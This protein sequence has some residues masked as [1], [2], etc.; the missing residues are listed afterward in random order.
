MGFI[1]KL[2]S[3]NPRVYEKKVKVKKPK[4]EI[5]KLTLRYVFNLKNWK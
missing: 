2:A 5:P 1:Q 4:R 3:R